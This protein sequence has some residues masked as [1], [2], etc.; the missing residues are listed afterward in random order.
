MLYPPYSDICVIGFTG[1]EET[2]VRNASIKF[3]ER[4]KELAASEYNELP[5][6]VLG[7]SPAAINR[8]KGKFRYKIIMKC[9]RSSRL[10]E[11]IDALLHEVG[12][13]RDFKDIQTFVD[14]NPDN[15]L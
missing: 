5:L 7:P 1:M 12:S 11:L 15:V 10:R 8:V 3:L 6:R 9:R 4:L 13:S 14:M 2:P